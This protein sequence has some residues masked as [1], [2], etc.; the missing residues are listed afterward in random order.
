MECKTIVR[1]TIILACT[2]P[3]LL[4][5]QWVQTN[6]P[7]CGKVTALAVR[8]TTLFAGSS[9]NGIFFS[10]NTGRAW[11]RVSDLIGNL[12]SLAVSGANLIAGSVGGGVYISTDD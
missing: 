7:N 2:A 9:G 5:S 6:G 12:S 8:G 4:K 11:A 1:V 3:S 10:T